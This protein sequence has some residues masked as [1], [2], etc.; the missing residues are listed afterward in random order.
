MSIQ[1]IRIGDVGVGVC[2]CHDDPESIIGV[3]VSGSGITNIEGPPAARIGDVLVCSCGHPSV[4]VMGSPITFA[5]GIPIS[6]IGDV[7]S[8]CPTGVMVSGAGKTFV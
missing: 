8:A 5:D 2:P 6:R 3:V 4:L 1:A 7:F